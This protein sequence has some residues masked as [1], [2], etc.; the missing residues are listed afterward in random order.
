M[1]KNPFENISTEHKRF[2]FFE[3]LGVYVPPKTY[4]IGFTSTKRKMLTTMAP[5]SVNATIEYIP[6]SETLRLF[7]EIPEMFG[8]IRNHMKK[9]CNEKNII[10]SFIQGNFWTRKR[11]SHGNRFYIP[12]FLYYDDFETRDPLGSHSGINKLG[13]TYISIPC[14][15]D[16]LNSKLS[17]IFLSTLSYG[18]DRKTYGNASIFKRCIEELNFL[19]THGITINI[20]G[21]KQQVYFECCLVLGDNLGMNGLLGFVE[22]FSANFFCR[23]CNA[24]S[25]DAKWMTAENKNKIRT[26][27]NYESDLEIKDSSR[28]GIKEPCVFHKIDG[29]HIAHNIS[30]DIMHDVFE[31]VANYCLVN[32]LKDFISDK[33]YPLFTLDVLNDRIELFDYGILEK[34]NKPPLISEDHIKANK[35]K[36][37][38]AEI[39]CFIRYFGF[40]AGDLIPEDDER[41]ELYT[42]LR[43]IIDIISSPKIT[44]SHIHLLEYYITEHLTLY[45]KLYGALKPKHHNMT[46]YPRILL[47][48]GPFINF[49]SMRYEAK[50]RNFK[51]TA[52]NTSCSKNLLKTLAVKNQLKYA[53]L[54][55]FNEKKKSYSVGTHGFI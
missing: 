5:V 18:N 47:E 44:K 34:S 11:A 38:A 23:L 26:E 24:S 46:H 39:A 31:G 4:N 21:V 35:I 33:R 7:L 49:W 25:S 52:S 13:G 2:Q 41:W 10:S 1:Y 45:I 53:Y 36:M 15:P 30:A 37:S 9:L 54:L 29:F 8:K 51:L 3:E 42:S 43:R 28:T 6:L 19:K 22:S 12:L 48:N 16:Y 17:S 14:L 40:M 32:I 55:M 50:H 20:G 27:V